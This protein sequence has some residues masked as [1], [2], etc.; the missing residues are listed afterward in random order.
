MKEIDDIQ[1]NRFCK[2]R[3]FFLVDFLVQGSKQI[4]IQVVVRGVWGG[5]GE[6]VYQYT[7][8]RPLMKINTDHLFL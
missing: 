4:I 3:N 1:T 8:K 6:F 5:G 7:L 2:S